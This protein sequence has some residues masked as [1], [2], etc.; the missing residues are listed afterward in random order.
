ME[1]T[2]KREDNCNVMITGPTD[3]GLQVIFLAT[4]MSSSLYHLI[5]TTTLSPL[6]Q[7][8]RKSALAFSGAE[9]LRVICEPN[10]QFALILGS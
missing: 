4:A 3:H 10:K 7:L 8:G 9:I 1:L 5:V 2:S 6:Y